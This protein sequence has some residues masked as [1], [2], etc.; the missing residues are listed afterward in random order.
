M[1][2]GD[3]TPEEFELSLLKVKAHPD[4]ITLG[5]GDDGRLLLHK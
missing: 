1:S 4:L 5:P 3:N 2:C